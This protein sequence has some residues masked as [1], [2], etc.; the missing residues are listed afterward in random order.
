ML[1]C[2]KDQSLLIKDIPDWLKNNI[3]ALEKEIKADPITMA[4]YTAWARYQWRGDYYFEYFDFASSSTIMPKRVDGQNLGLVD[5]LYATYQN[6]KC[7]MDYVWKGPK[8]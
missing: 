7:C 5:P 4:A 2:Q 8:Y 1:S 3:S 6:E